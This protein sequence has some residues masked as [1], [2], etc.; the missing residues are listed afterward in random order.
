MILGALL[1]LA[2]LVTV[3][4][5]GM[6]VPLA[7]EGAR[8][9]VLVLNS[10]EFELAGVSLR[11]S[12]DGCE[13]VRVTPAVVEKL[14]PSDRV[15][16]AIELRRTPQTRSARL[17][18]KVEVVAGSEPLRTLWLAVDGHPPPAGEGWIDVGVIKVHN[19]RPWTRS[20]VYALLVLLPVAALVGFGWW[21]RRRD[22][23]QDGG[24]RI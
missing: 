21:V 10:S 19:T 23:R 17:P 3:V 22:R 14:A 11:A 18:L 2:E 9:E 12:A 8:A 6:V 1:L 24:P 4:P 13:V 5:E 20:L 7:G 15:V 16:F